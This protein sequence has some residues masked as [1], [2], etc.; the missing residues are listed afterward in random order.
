LTDDLIA[1]LEPGENVIGAARSMALEELS[2]RPVPALRVVVKSTVKLFT[3]HSVGALSQLL[4]RPYAQTGL[5][6]RFVLGEGN[7]VVTASQ[8]APL[9]LAAA[10][11]FLNMFLVLL[12]FA[13]VLWTFIRRSWMLPLTFALPVLLF[14]AAT[15]AVGLERLRV[16]M[17][18]PLLV[19]TALGISGAHQWLARTRM[20]SCAYASAATLLASTTLALLL[21]LSWA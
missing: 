9:S 4:G 12:A 19:L 8:V 18:A 21:F 10:W 1:R 13:G 16:P 17:M 5:V 11:T 3:D 14:A 2:H 15:G 20:Q 6:S 7:T